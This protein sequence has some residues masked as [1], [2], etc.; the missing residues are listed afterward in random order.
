[1]DKMTKGYLLP[2]VIVVNVLPPYPLCRHWL[3]AA[4]GLSPLPL[5]LYGAAHQSLPHISASMCRGAGAAGVSRKHHSQPRHSSPPA[6]TTSTKPQ[7]LRQ[8]LGFNFFVLH[9]ERFWSSD[10]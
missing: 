3:L 9:K 1:M 10:S 4:P 6:A 8:D 2:T 7:D 5:C